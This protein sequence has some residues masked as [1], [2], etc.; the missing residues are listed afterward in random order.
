MSYVR[1]NDPL[2]RWLACIDRC[3]VFQVWSTLAMK[4]LVLQM[5]GRSFLTGLLM[6]LLVTSC[7][8]GH[9]IGADSVV[10]Q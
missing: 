6:E 4:S 10:V 5:I 7:E 2:W 3:P 9:A 1:C 8:L